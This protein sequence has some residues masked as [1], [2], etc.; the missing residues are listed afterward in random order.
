MLAGV[1]VFWQMMMLPPT[2]FIDNQEEERFELQVDNKAVFADYRREQGVLHILHV[3][4]PA[5]LRGTG[6][7]GKL[8]EEIAQYAKSSKEKLHP[9]CSYAAV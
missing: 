5:S 1:S 7:A 3:E 4:A 6:A 9:I 8:M 2:Y